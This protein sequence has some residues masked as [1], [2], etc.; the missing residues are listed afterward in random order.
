MKRAPGSF[1]SDK[2]ATLKRTITTQQDL[3]TNAESAFNVES[4]FAVSALIAKR[5]KPFTDGEFVKEYILT[6]VDIATVT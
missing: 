4:S 3:F 2:I 5:L 6:V 1:A